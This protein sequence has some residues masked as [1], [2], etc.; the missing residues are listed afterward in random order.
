M[1]EFT[2]WLQGHLPEA[3]LGLAMVLGVA[4]MFSL[5]LIL[6]MLA[7]GAVAGMLAALLGLP[8]A[9]QV[10]IAAAAALGPQRKETEKRPNS[11]PLLQGAARPRNNPVRCV[12]VKG[13]WSCSRSAARS[14]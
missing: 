12:P 1:N 13:D 2:D 6:I 4:E 10:L 8:F 5:D 3:W 11:R 9:V 7:G 14:R